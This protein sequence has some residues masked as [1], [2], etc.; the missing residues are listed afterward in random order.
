MNLSFYREGTVDPGHHQSHALGHRSLRDVGP[1]STHLQHDEAI[2]VIAPPHH[3]AVRGILQH[4][5]DA[6]VSGA[7]AAGV[8]PRG[9]AYLYNL[10]TWIRQVRPGQPDPATSLSLRC[11]A[12]NLQSRSSYSHRPPG[13]WNRRRPSR[14]PRPPVSPSALDLYARDDVGGGEL[15]R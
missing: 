3:L 6:S 13:Y 5:V 7:A 1:R 10:R 4:P 9:E 11:T 12:R 14:G 8:R 15:L 2:A